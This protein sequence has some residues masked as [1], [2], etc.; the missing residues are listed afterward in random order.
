MGS[1]DN[2]KDTSPPRQGAAGSI[3]AILQDI[4]NILKESDVEAYLLDELFIPDGS[5]DNAA[6]RIISNPGDD[7]FVTPFQK[8]TFFRYMNELWDLLRSTYSIVADEK[9]G[10]IRAEALLLMDTY[11]SY[12]ALSCPEKAQTEHAPGGTGSTHNS[13]ASLQYTL[14]R[15]LEDLN[16]R[17]FL[18]DREIRELNELLEILTDKTE[19]LPP[20]R[21]R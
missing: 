18:S 19:A 8:E 9:S 5:V 21:A 7:P 1:I 11:L 15:L 17:R 6:V 13:L 12:Y 16:T 10:E 14:S 2:K 3:D 4:G 20:S